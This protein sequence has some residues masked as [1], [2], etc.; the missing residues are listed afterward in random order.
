MD[1]PITGGEQYT[2]LERFRPYLEKRAYG[3]VQPDAGICG[4]TECLR[5]A[6]MADQYGVDL[7]PH[8]WHNGLMC[9]AHAHLVAG[10]P[11]A[12]AVPA[13]SGRVQNVVELCLIQG[14]LQ[15]GMLAEKPLIEDGWLLLPDKPGLGVDLA[16]NVVE[17]YPHVEGHYGVHI[18]RD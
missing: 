7:C 12:A 17:K 16:E 8:S 18:E 1:L 11:H 13:Q 14:P 10:L 6:E 2:T 3:I 9:M 4:I 5:I 15:W